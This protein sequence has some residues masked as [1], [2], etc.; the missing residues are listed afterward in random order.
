MFKYATSRQ[1]AVIAA[2]YVGKLVDSLDGELEPCFISDKLDEK[3]PKVEKLRDAAKKFYNL[4]LT[5]SM[6]E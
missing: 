3:N 6:N 1:A 4:L 2:V 5:V